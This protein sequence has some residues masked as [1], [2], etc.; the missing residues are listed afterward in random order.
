MAFIP[1][2]SDAAVVNVRENPLHEGLVVA[3]STRLGFAIAVTKI[4]RKSPTSYFGYSVCV[5][6][7]ENP[8]SDGAEVCAIHIGEDFLLMP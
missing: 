1:R 8:S 7:A 2:A 5:I 4:V 3:P 6:D